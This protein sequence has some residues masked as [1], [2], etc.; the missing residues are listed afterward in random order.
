MNAHPLS[1]RRA[2]ASALLALAP[3]G[4]LAATT[5]YDPALGSLPLA[6]GWQPLVPL[7]G[8]AASQSVGGGVYALD[9]TGAGVSIWG[10]SRISPLALDTQAGFD[11]SFSLQLLSESHSRPNRA[12]FALMLVGAQATQALELEFWAGN[13]WAQKYDASQPD[14]FVHDS[15]VAFDTTAALTPYTLAM[16]QQQ[17]TLSAGGTALLWGALRDYTLGGLPYTTPNFLFLGDNSSRGNSI[18]RLGVVS[19]SPVPE[20]AAGWLMALGLAGLALRRR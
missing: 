9:T 13:I 15:D 5:L 10:N 20:P 2:L 4:A 12:G 6:Q 18:S 3:L 1:A 14:R 19:L 11:L 8:A 16:R 7:I 17:F